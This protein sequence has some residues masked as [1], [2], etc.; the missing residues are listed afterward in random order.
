MLVSDLSL[1]RRAVRALSFV[2]AFGGLASSAH[3][4]AQEAGLSFVDRTAE[5]REPTTVLRSE[6]PFR[7]DT[8]EIELGAISLGVLEYKITMSAGDTVVYSWASPVDV[9]VEFHGHTDP[10]LNPVMDVVFYDIVDGAAASGTLTAPMDGM[11]GW[12]FR[13]RTFETFKVQLTMAGFYE[14]GPGLR[15]PQTAPP[16]AAQ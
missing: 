14:L 5:L 2:L 13:N 15:T 16:T 10:A 1:P 11:H 4:W 8:I 12:Y 9:H 7:T 6:R 3:G